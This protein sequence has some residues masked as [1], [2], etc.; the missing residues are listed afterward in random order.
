[1]N[2]IVIHMVK[3]ILDNKVDAFAIFL[4]IASLIRSEQNNRNSGK[5]MRD[6]SFMIVQQISL[7]NELKKNIVTYKRKPNVLNLSKDGIRL[8]KLYGFKKRD[9][10]SIMENINHLIIKGRFKQEINNFS[11]KM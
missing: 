5:I 2:E 4:A 6:T 9:I 3:W 8:H 7:L 10:P 1:M 11:D